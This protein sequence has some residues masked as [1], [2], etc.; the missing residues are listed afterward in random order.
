MEANMKYAINLLVT[1]VIFGLTSVSHAAVVKYEVH[2]GGFVYAEIKNSVSNYHKTHT[3]PGVLDERMKNRARMANMA[4]AKRQCSQ[5]S[6]RKVA[7][8]ETTYCTEASSKTR[9][10]RRTCYVKNSFLCK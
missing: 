8:E 2:D 6:T 1:L 7:K 10:A 5:F 9:M 4:E 3:Y